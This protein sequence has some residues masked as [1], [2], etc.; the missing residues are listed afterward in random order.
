[1]RMLDP[2][3][4]RRASVRSAKGRRAGARRTGL[5]QKRDKKTTTQEE[6]RVLMNFSAETTTSPAHNSPL[7]QPL[8]R[9]ESGPQQNTSSG[10]LHPAQSRYSGTGTENEQNPNS[11]ALIHQLQER[12]QPCTESEPDQ[13]N[14]KSWTNS[15]KPN[16]CCA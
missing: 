9:E 11:S 16:F 10:Q 7:H 4:G 15:S 13:A 12:I 8:G 6:L 14:N 5:A 1:M 2:P 3:V